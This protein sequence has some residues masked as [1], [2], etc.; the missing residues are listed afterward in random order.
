M[1]GRPGPLL[2]MRMRGDLDGLLEPVP[3]LREMT[4]LTW[5]TTP[6]VEA[7]APAVLTSVKKLEFLR[8]MN[9]HQLDSS[10]LPTERRRFPSTPPASRR[11]LDQRVLLPRRPRTPR[12]GT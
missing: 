7:T 10:M 2:T 11:R 8:G 3:E 5:L 4:R 12:P 6:A 1:I 9:A